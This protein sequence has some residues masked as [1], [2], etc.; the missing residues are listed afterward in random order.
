MENPGGSRM[1]DVGGIKAQS[2]SYLFP[3]AFSFFH[4]GYPSIFSIRRAV[5]VDKW[6]EF[7]TAVIGF[8]RGH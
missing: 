3:E 1:I 7:L 6:D 5:Q 8:L 2:V 4:L